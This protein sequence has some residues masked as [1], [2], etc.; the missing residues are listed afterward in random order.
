[1]TG[2]QTCALRSVSV[3]ETEVNPYWTNIFD[4]DKLKYF[5]EE[6][7]DIT[8]RQ[9]LPEIYRVNGAVYFI[10]TDIL[11]RK[12]MFLTEN[13]TGYIMSNKHSVDIDTEM[14]FKLAEMIIKEH[15]IDERRI[16]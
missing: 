10:K 5:I 4:G 16:K 12:N 9:D 2:V 11:V 1:M 8:R 3:C 7:K 6:G 15:L 14:D 13:T